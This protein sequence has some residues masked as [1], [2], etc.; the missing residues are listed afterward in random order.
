MEKANNTNK[1]SFENLKNLLLDN[2]YGIEIDETA[3]KVAA[4]SLYLALID[5][6]DPKT[7]WIETNYQLP[8]LIFDSEDTN[9]KNQGRNLW[10]KDTIG[11]VDTH[12]FPKVDLI[13][14]NPPFGTKTYH[15]QSKS[16]VPNINFQMS[17]YFHSFINQL[18]FVQRERLL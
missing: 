13:I 11:E 10:R 16:I 18:N 8:Y 14:G 3:I 17:M 6:L 2:I 5:E 7:L 1:I 4:F 9:I 15:K 12:L